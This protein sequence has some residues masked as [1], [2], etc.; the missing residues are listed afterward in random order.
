MLH[1]SCC[2]WDIEVNCAVR[3]AYFTMA[4]VQACCFAV[5]TSH[6][7]LAVLVLSKTAAV[8]A[9]S[10]AASFSLSL[11]FL[12]RY[13]KSVSC[14]KCKCGIVIALSMVT[15]SVSKLIIVLHCTEKNQLHN[16]LLLSAFNQPRLFLCSTLVTQVP[17]VSHVKLWVS[18]IYFFCDPT[19]SVKALLL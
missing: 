3:T 2:L 13:Q 11:I 1:C 9:V 17:N 18:D 10:F 15:P 14:T 7:S 8:S 4:N 12:R 16:Y 19:N 5:I 6:W